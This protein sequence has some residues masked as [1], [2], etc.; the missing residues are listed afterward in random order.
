MPVTF[1]TRTDSN[2]ANNPNLNFTGAP[3]VQITFVPSGTGGDV[4]LEGGGVAD[5]DTLVEI[6]GATYS[7]TF[8]FSA[9]TPTASNQG[10]NQYP[11]DLQDQQII[12]I[13][14]FDYPAPG[15]TTRL[16]FLPEADATQAQMD[17]IG[18]GAN[19]P[20]GIDE[21]GPGVICFAAGTHLH[22]PDGERAVENLKLG[23]LVTT[24]DDGPL[25]IIWIASTTYTWPGTD[26][27]ALPVRIA[28]SALEPGRPTRDLIVSPQH[29]VLLQRDFGDPGILAPAKGLTGLPGIR[30]MR[31]K[32]QVR[33]YHIL[34]QRHAI[35]LPEGLP[36]ESF[37]PGPMALR[38][39]SPEN[40]LSL[41]AAL[42]PS[43]VDYGPLARRTLKV[44]ETRA[45]AHDLRTCAGPHGSYAAE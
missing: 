18:T 28:R 3:S 40:W 14:V 9:T 13:T 25:P 38:M 24:L 26:E 21:I 1:W 20:Q 33:Y 37:Y 36:S 8:E 30:V 44:S 12:V 4:I 7:F 16:A 45:L 29:R 6:D 15:D 11:A 39:L 23:D 27:A 31:G 19:R 17:S 5:P 43:R 32:R 2:T 35:V 10:G 42:G 41:Q 34:L 22:T